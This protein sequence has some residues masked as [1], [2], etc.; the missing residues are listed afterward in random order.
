MNRIL[1]N[2]ATS[3]GDEPTPGYVYNEIYQMTFSSK[4]SLTAVVDFLIKKLQR[5]D[6]NVKFK[7][8]K[9]LKHLCDNKRLDIRNYLKKKIEVIKE[10]QTCNI[11]NDELKG[12]TPSMQVRKEATELLKLIYSYDTMEN[13]G[14]S[15]L[16]EKEIIPKNR[17]VGFGNVVYEKEKKTHMQ[18]ENLMF[19]FNGKDIKGIDREERAT[20]R[21]VSN[22][23][24]RF[25][26]CTNISERDETYFSKS[27]HLNHSS[28]ATNMSN[29]TFNQ[30]IN[31]SGGS[32][33]KMTGFGNPHFNQYPVQKTK[34]EIAIKYINAVANRYIPSTFVNK[35]EKVSAQITKNYS[36]GSLNLQNIISMNGYGDTK[37]KNSDVEQIKRKTHHMR[38]NNHS[39]HDVYSFRKKETEKERRPRK[40][41]AAGTY[42]RKVV[43]D[44]LD[45]TGAVKKV[46]TE[47]M[48]LEFA[49]KCEALD[50][51]LIV[52]ILTEKLQ[53]NFINE[54]E[55]WKHKYKVLC[56]IEYLLIYKKGKEKGKTIETLESLTHN[57]K[58]QTLEELYRCKSVK[59]LKKKVNDI[60][61]LLGLQPK[62]TTTEKMTSKQIETGKQVPEEVQ[63][64]KIEMEIPD[65]LDIDDNDLGTANKNSV[66]KEKTK[67]SFPFHNNVENIVK[68]VSINSKG[69]VDINNRNSDKIST[70]NDNCITEFVERDK[71]QNKII[72]EKND[73]VKNDNEK[74]DN[75]K[76]SCEDFFLYDTQSFTSSNK[77]CNRELFNSLKVKNLPTKEECKKDALHTTKDEYDLSHLNNSF[78]NQTELHNSKSNVN[79]INAN[80]IFMEEEEEE[81]KEKGQGR[82]GGRA[83]KGGREGGE[84]IENLTLINNVSQLTIDKKKEDPENN[85]NW[86]PLNVETDVVNTSISNKKTSENTLETFTLI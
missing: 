15:N 58:F 55:N 35:I 56:V 80:L 11:I 42:E 68:S 28:S 21:I 69:P 19:S 72:N 27:K 10:C 76:R 67:T 34:K 5:T 33:S 12:E 8:L 20:G 48:L 13:T 22:H 51:K 23:A 86:L 81:E 4:E 63:T 49:Q 85:F 64:Q 2:K 57:L 6:M 84:D 7:T 60:F 82:R 65:L 36:E 70:Y 43:E 40:S 29:N 73:N 50:T 37:N 59:Q 30:G 41:E 32:S 3:S 75:E 83:G 71:T 16:N 24:N 26:S 31:R 9:V 38:R 47:S 18:N 74:H 45:T 44:V 62:T 46:P 25:S 14:K 79:Q 66:G 39:S 17:I 1:L 53:I 54:E 52:S 77:Q 78:C 61:V